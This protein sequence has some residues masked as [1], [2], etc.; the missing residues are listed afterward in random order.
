LL[1]QHAKGWCWNV[2]KSNSVLSEETQSHVKDL[3]TPFSQS[4]LANKL[5]AQLDEDQLTNCMRCGFC[6]PA[7][8]TYRETGIEAESPRGRIALMKAVADGLM[9]PDVVFAEQMNHCLGCRACEPACPADVKYGQLLE[10]ARDAIDQHPP[11]SRGFANVIGFVVFKLLFPHRR[12]MR[13]LG[14][15]LAFYQKSGLQKWITKTGLLRF[16]PR[17][18][19]EMESILPASSGKGVYE[20]IGDIHPAIG[21]KIATVALFRGCVMDVSFTQTNINT[22]KILQQAGFEVV[23]P[24]EQSCC[25]ALHA[26]SGQLELARKQARQNIQVFQQAKVDYIVSNAGGCGAILVEY[27]HLLHEDLAWQ[28]QAKWF[29][30]RVID[31][32]ELIVKYGRRLHFHAGSTEDILPTNMGDQISPHYPTTTT[33]HSQMPA[34]VTQSSAQPTI[35][36]YQDSCHLR[37]VMKSSQAP[38]ELIRSVPNIQFVEMKEADRCCGSAGVYNL[39]QPEMASQI[40]AHKMENV[41][42]TQAQLILTSNPGC[43]LQMKLG[44]A[45]HS[46]PAQVKVEH[47]VDFLYE[48]MSPTSD[49]SD[50]HTKT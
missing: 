17:H 30:S 12:M 21:E 33:V 5:K 39:T 6:L 49:T 7:C 44:V 16:L 14:Y 3:Y 19:Q 50:L 25:G 13:L 37:N 2:V 43:L 40:L 29:A 45:R 32:S 28:E 41:E 35:V 20:H 10:Q 22:A 27:D 23:I 24:P 46:N 47:I 34:H 48:R 9:D 38:R 42:K 36:T 1:S 26:H 31:V 4:P 11:T 8:P 15:S 18:L